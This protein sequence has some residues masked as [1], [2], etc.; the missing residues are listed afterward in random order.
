[1]GRFDKLREVTKRLL[2]VQGQLMER[3]KF[4]DLPNVA[5]LAKIQPE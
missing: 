1:L 3:L 2:A 5:A 4:V